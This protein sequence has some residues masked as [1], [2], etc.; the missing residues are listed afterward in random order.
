MPFGKLKFVPGGQTKKIIHLNDAL[1]QK[2]TQ[3]LTINSLNPVG[4]KVFYVSG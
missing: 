1:E 2:S 3:D 4:V